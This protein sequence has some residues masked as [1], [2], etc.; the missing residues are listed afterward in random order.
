MDSANT[1]AVVTMMATVIT[2]PIAAALEWN[3]IGTYSQKNSI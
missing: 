2:L 1:F 3:K